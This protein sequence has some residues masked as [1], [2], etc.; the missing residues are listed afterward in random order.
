MNLADTTLSKIFGAFYLLLLVLGFFIALFW[1]SFLLPRIFRYRSEYNTLVSR[2]CYSPAEFNI[3]V[4]NLK[5]RIIIYTFLIL[6]VSS[7][8]LSG[9]SHA[10]G[11]LSFTFG[12][13]GP[14]IAQFSLNI[15]LDCFPKYEYNIWE[16]ELTYPVCAFLMIL[17]DLSMCMGSI[18]MIALL[19]FLFLA[20]QLKTNFRN[21]KMFLIKFCTVLL[22]LF[23]ISI[24]P[25]TQIFSKM[26]TPILCITIIY[27]LFKHRA[28]YFHI[29]RKRCNDTF[30]DR[31]HKIHLR[32]KRNSIIT[33]NIILFVYIIF[34]IALMNVELISFVV[35]IFT[36]KSRVLSAVYNHDINLTF[37]PCDYQRIIYYIQYYVV[38]LIQVPI[39]LIALI[40]YLIPQ[41]AIM[42]VFIGRYLYR[43]C[44]GIDS[45]YIRF[46]GNAHYY[47][48]VRY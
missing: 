36:E 46:E 41:Y 14:E 35:M 38:H 31:D 7:E 12:F 47:H 37:F 16:F 43:Q 44:R 15:T 26:I 30:G 5:V 4:F 9:L 6:I 11:L 3:D 17:G 28:G 29:L 27:L 8:F 48:R 42:F 34:L 20:Y 1:F 10:L 32:T 21:V 18:L 33:F 22:F 25:Q 39:V 2:W 19:K 40:L 24:I 45:R 13:H 23:I